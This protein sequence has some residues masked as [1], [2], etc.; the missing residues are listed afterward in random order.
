MTLCYNSLCKVL[1]QNE[2]MSVHM[3]DILHWLLVQQ[4]IIIGS[5]ASLETCR[6][7][8]LLEFF[9][10]TSACAGHRSLYSASIGDF[11]VL[12]AC[13]ATR[14]RRALLIV[15]TSVWNNLP[16]DLRSLPCDLSSSFINF[17]TSL[18]PSLGW[19]CLWIVILKGYYISLIDR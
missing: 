8:N 17:S 12:L 14:Q 7:A 16:S 13:T 19:K 9:I 4:L 2:I 10:L 3:Q 11:V 15:G 1:F 18:W 5:S 6:P